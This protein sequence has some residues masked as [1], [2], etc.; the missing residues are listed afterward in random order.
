MPRRAR[1]I[2]GGLVYHVL[3]RANGGLPLFRKPEDYAAFQHVVE[4]AHTRESLR[5]LAYCVMRWRRS[6]VGQARRGFTKGRLARE[7]CCASGR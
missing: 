4:E 2:Q 7:H 6:G 3:N 5:I 1:S